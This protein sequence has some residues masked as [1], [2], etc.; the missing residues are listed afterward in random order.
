MP[1]AFRA[2]LRPIR[3]GDEEAMLFLVRTAEL[4]GP[5]RTIARIDDPVA[6]RALLASWIGPRAPN[7]SLRRGLLGGT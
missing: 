1:A 4:T 2:W 3:E 6:A 7:A 5:G